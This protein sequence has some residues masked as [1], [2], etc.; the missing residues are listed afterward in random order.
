MVICW[1][2][3]ECMLKDEKK[4]RKLKNPENYGNTTKAVSEGHQ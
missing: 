2:D 3:D 4:N 1:S